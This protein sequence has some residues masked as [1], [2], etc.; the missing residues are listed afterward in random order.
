[1]LHL[2]IRRFADSAFGH[3]TAA[4][5]YAIMRNFRHRDARHRRAP[6]PTARV[7]A[8]SSQP[9]GTT[10]ALGPYCRLREVRAEGLRTAVVFR[11]DRRQARG[12]QLPVP[13]DRLAVD[14]AQV[15]LRVQCTQLGGQAC[16]RK[17]LQLRQTR[18]WARLKHTC[19]VNNTSSSLQI[20]VSV[21][22][23]RMSLGQGCNHTDIRPHKL[24]AQAPSEPYKPGHGSSCFGSVHTLPMVGEQ[25]TSA[26]T[27]SRPAPAKPMLSVRHATRSAAMPAHT[28][29]SELAWMGGRHS[30]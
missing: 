1:M 29:S 6:V 9:A 16:S 18:D 20:P 5:R 4:G 21:P 26:A 12:Q 19:P 25:R 7:R 15:D 2:F 23:H 22:A 8:V 14:D 30:H 27:R 10:A 28:L 17:Q 11:D 13:D 3:S 24:A